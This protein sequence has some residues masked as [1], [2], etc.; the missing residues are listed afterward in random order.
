[1]PSMIASTSCRAARHV[2]VF[3]K[4]FQTSTYSAACRTGWNGRARSIHTTPIALKKKGPGAAIDDLFDDSS[5]SGDLFGSSAQPSSQHSPKSS[6]TK[7]TAKKFANHIPTKK[8]D[9]TERKA[10]FDQLYESLI[11]HITKI[12]PPPRNPASLADP[13][14][15]PE[16]LEKKRARKQLKPIRHTVW[17][18]LLDLAQTEEDLVKLVDLFPKWQDFGHKFDD[19]FGEHFVARC[20]NLKCPTLALKVF[21]D[22]AKYAVPLPL[23][24]ARHL[25][26][27]LNAHSSLSDV[28]MA[29]ALYHVYNL[30]PVAEDV[31]SCAIVLNA[32]LKNAQ[33]APSPVQK[34]EEAGTAAPSSN[35]STPSPTKQRSA[36]L[37]IARGLLP[38]LHTLLDKSEP[39]SWAVPRTGQEKTKIVVTVKGK[40]KKK[41]VE[42]AYN[43]EKVWVS[44][45]LSKV[46]NFLARSKD[47]LGSAEWLKQW[48]IREGHL[49]LKPTETP[50]AQVAA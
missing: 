44:W 4:S 7:P 2:G 43:R 29:A 13:T 22:H 3:S 48:R 35:A 5:D 12:L 9:P 1:M 32:T 42:K 28:L 45:C 33:N 41:K 34:A 11:P 26:F 21:G 27:S 30:P 14:K 16:Y 6:A 47:G 37:Q 39:R 20:D 38:S 31:T 24:A 15:D 49:K 8:L 50:Q 40:G 10:R 36:S 25:L 18:H 46:Q 23:P 19:G 17:D